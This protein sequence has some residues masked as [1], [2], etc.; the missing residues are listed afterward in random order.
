MKFLLDM[1]ISHT[2]AG[3]LRSIGHDA[4]HLREQNLQ[5]LG[6]EDIVAK[7]YEEK[8]IILVH[9][10]DF[11]RMVALS[12]ERLPSVITFR[13][14]DMRAQNVNLYVTEVLDRFA[15]ELEIGGLVSVMDDTIRLRR[16]PVERP[17]R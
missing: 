7:A 11:G 8:R 2:T 10:L 13:L 4:V 9:D 12:G 3:F 16:L 1:G 14:S 15:E 5:R 6:D 17:K